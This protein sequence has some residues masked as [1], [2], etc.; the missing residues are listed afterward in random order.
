[1]AESRIVSSVKD[2]EK[3]NSEPKW[4]YQDLCALQSFHTFILIYFNI[5]L[6]FEKNEENYYLMALGIQNHILGSGRHKKLIMK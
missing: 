6:Y 1:V 3:H 5:L 2:G 4:S